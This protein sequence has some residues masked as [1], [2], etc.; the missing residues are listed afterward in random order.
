M[1]QP[2]PTVSQHSAR[3]Q[4]QPPLNRAA[5]ASRINPTGKFPSTPTPMASKTWSTPSVSMPSHMQQQAIHPRPQ[6]PSQTQDY[7][8]YRPPSR[9][10]SRQHGHSLHTPVQQTQAEPPMTLPRATRSVDGGE[11]SNRFNATYPLAQSV[12]GAFIPPATFLKSASASGRDQAT[13]P[14]VYHAQRDTVEMF[15]PEDEIDAH[16]QITVENTLYNRT[17]L[18]RFDDPDGQETP[19]VHMSQDLPP[20]SQAHRSREEMRF[21]RSRTPSVAT[22]V[23]NGSRLNGGNVS[24]DSSAPRPTF[25]GH[26]FSEKSHRPTLDEALGDVHSWQD[27]MKIEAEWKTNEIA[28]LQGETKRLQDIAERSNAERHRAISDTRQ[29]ANVIA[30]LTSQLNILRETARRTISDAEEKEAVIQEQQSS[31]VA[32][33]KGLDEDVKTFRESEIK[34]LTNAVNG[35]KSTIESIKS[36]LAEFRDVSASEGVIAEL[37]KK[38]KELARTIKD[39]NDANVRLQ[40]KVEHYETMVGPSIRKLD[41]SVVDLGKTSDLTLLSDATRRNEGLQNKLK[42]T[43]QETIN[44]R[45]QLDVSNEKCERYGNLLDEHLNLFRQ[46]GCEGYDIQTL[47]DDLDRKYRIE[48]ESRVRELDDEKFRLQQLQAQLDKLD[49]DRDAFIA[50]DNQQADQSARIEEYKAK[51]RSMEKTIDTQARE[52]DLLGEANQKSLQEVQRL[53]DE[54][55]EVRSESDAQRHEL[56]QCHKDLEQGAAA[57][58]QVTIELEQKTTARP[59]ETSEN[60]EAGIE[61]MRRGISTDSEKRLV[62]WAR[63]AVKVDFT[64]K[65]TKLRTSPSLRDTFGKADAKVTTDPV[66]QVK[67]LTSKIRKLEEG[68]AAPK[69]QIVEPQDVD[70]IKK[71]AS[72]QEASS[73][74]RMDNARRVA[75]ENIKPT[76]PRTGDART[77]GKRAWNAAHHESSE[78]RE[79][80]PPSQKRRK[81]ARVIQQD[82]EDE[83]GEFGIDNETLGQVQLENVG[84][85]NRHDAEESTPADGPG[86]SSKSQYIEIDELADSQTDQAEKTSKSSRNHKPSESQ[87]HASV[88]QSATTVIP[89]VKHNAKTKSKA[90]NR[91]L[92]DDSDYAPPIKTKKSQKKA[93][94]GQ[95]AR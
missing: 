82:S 2:F 33:I 74:R 54:I 49:D 34:H 55:A 76:S 85:S 11:T 36:K 21:T 75:K 60:P 77:N 18:G 42:D 12:P 28:Y 3:S 67:S 65:E 1:S 6:N 89:K 68:E 94:E 92:D 29:K 24:P 45:H 31:V 38:N 26:K 71:A 7:N 46:K 32:Q 87:A 61:R 53:K 30:E 79:M 69:K 95:K 63:N 52:K 5:S 59:A 25:T 44:L 14:E 90:V 19:P 51:V 57:L 37:E 80:P 22:S 35:Y 58:K 23:I 15:H 72:T 9:S 20:S 81:V 66:N 48:V 91:G 41:K 40:A 13:G 8:H 62:E 50:K 10:T 93:G 47:L 64:E 27:A 70:T 39:Q 86:S 83:Y 16:D 17:K 43:E 88:E 4:P 84:K 73:S 78:E 56:R